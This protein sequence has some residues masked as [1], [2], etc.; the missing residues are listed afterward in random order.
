MR[1]FI[2]TRSGVRF[3][4]DAPRPESIRI[5]DICFALSHLPRFTGHTRG[6]WSVA[7]HSLLVHALAA[8]EHATVRAACLLHDA[9][10]AY[11][12]DISTPMKGLIPDVREIEDNITVAIERRTY[13]PILATRDF[14]KS[15]DILAY[16][17]EVMF[18]FDASTHEDFFSWVD[19]QDMPNRIE[20]ERIVR[21]LRVV[22]SE[23]KTPGLA[24]KTLETRIRRECSLLNAKPDLTERRSS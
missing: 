1:P 12:G 18:F 8:H 16:V 5:S 11:T 13:V 22:L 6:R 9:S 14:W 19:E 4:L 17:G 24:A 10:E 20:I 23:T 7:Q 2:I 3:Q 21:K 15:Y